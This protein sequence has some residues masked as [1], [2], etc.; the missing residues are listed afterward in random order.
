MSESVANR[1]RIEDLEPE[2]IEPVLGQRILF[3]SRRADG[4]VAPLEL[5]LFRVARLPER[6]AGARSRGVRL[7]ARPFALVFRSAD[8]C[9]TLLAS[10]ELDD[11][12]FERTPLLLTPV[13]PWPNDAP[14]LFYYEAVFN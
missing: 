6:P 11:P 2:H 8:D 4:S 3:R 1:I 14:G 9:R 10:L 5:E 7:R 13:L 12:R